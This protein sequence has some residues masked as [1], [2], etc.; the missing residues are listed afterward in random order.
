MSC[1]FSFPTVLFRLGGASRATSQTH[2]ARA[3]WL[4]TAEIS[5]RVYGPS[6]LSLSSDHPWRGGSPLSTALW[7]SPNPVSHWPH[8]LEYHR[9]YSHSR[10]PHSNW[11][12][13]HGTERRG[14]DVQTLPTDS[15]ISHCEVNAT[16]V[17][18]MQ[19]YFLAWTQ[20]V[21]RRANPWAVQIKCT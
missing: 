2:C 14:R 16:F 11:N 8:S 5:E 19:F 21:N 3:Q 18:Q 20:M 7:R 9:S 6:P 4:Q 13:L 15:L 1:L 17:R 12:H 10:T